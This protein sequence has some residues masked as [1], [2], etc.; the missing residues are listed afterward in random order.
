VNG[1]T[2]RWSSAI[3]G[4][5]LL[6]GIGSCQGNASPDTNVPGSP[7]MT[8]SE[9]RF[10]VRNERAEIVD[11]AISREHLLHG[12]LVQV[13]GDARQ[14][15]IVVLR[16]SHRSGGSPVQPPEQVRYQTVIVSSGAGKFTES[17]G[18]YLKR[19]AYETLNTEPER[20]DLT[21]IGYLPFTAMTTLSKSS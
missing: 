21:V 2:R 16:I 6:F 13:G 11:L 9:T 14:S 10:E 5:I 20:V 4:A 19:R 18:F 17:T 1:R 3:G 15:F 8:A 12:T 7:A